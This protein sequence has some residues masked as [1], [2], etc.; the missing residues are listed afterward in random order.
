MKISLADLPFHS[1]FYHDFRWQKVAGQLGFKPQ[2]FYAREK[3]K[4]T[5][6]LPL[7]IKKG[8]LGG[9]RLVSLPFGEAGPLGE[10]KIQRQLLDEALT[11]AERF[12]ANLEIISLQKIAQLP[13][14]FVQRDEYSYYILETD[15]SYKEVFE[16]SY[17]KKT[18]NMVRKAD[19]AGIRVTSGSVTDLD[20]FY[21]L[22]LITMRKLGALPFPYDV[23]IKTWGC[24][25]K[26]TKLLRAM[27]EGEI[28]GFLW[29]FEWK[30]VIWIWANATSEKSLSLGINYA[31]YSQAIKL[32]CKNKQI[33]QINFGGSE[34]DSSQEFFKLRW[35]AEK[36]P[37]F[38][39]SNYSSG[40]QKKGLQN[41]LKPIINNMP[42]PLLR[43]AGR[44][45]YMLY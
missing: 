16:K 42:I 29:V 1:F 43:L 35:G 8:L 12:N 21:N 17:H 32:A 41:I 4:L 10:T 39:I 14:G 25:P 5:G 13:K 28:A 45:G 22:Y 26:E 37:V 9:T 33:K 34:S 23:F 20:K 38:I 3:G 40:N 24:F 6:L 44:L 19:K 2:Y 15:S 7:F 31:L 30:K 11:S 18:R 36:K 27:F